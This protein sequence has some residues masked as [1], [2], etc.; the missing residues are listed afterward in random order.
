MGVKIRSDAGGN[1]PAGSAVSVRI[2]E[3]GHSLVLGRIVQQPNGLGDNSIAIGSNQLHSTGIDG[4]GPFCLLPQHENWLAQRRAFF[5][6]ASRIGDRA[7]RLGASG[8][9]TEHNPR[10]QLT[11]RWLC[12]VWLRRLSSE[13]GDWGG[14]ARRFERRRAWPAA[15]LRRKYARILLRSSPCD[16]RLQRSASLLVQGQ[17]KAG[18]SPRSRASRMV[19]T[20]SI[21]C[22]P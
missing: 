9:R 20:A 15:R 5:L 14:R 13:H 22:C 19:R 4:F 2:V 21:Q 3:A 16:E 7:D 17:G 1:S 6:H 8:P 11:R 18:D 10:G 12:R